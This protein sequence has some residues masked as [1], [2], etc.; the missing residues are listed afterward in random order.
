M[1][2]LV[3]ATL[4]DGTGAAPLED[5]EVEIRDG[6]IAYA[7]PRRSGTGPE[8]RTVDVSGA[9][10]LPGFVDV[11]VH[12]AMVPVAPEAARERF[13]EEDVLEIAGL[14][15]RTLDA[16]V[17]TARDLDGLSRA[18]ARPSHAA[19][20]R[21]RACTSRSP[22]SRRPAATPIRTTATAACRPGPCARACPHPDWWTRTRTSSAWSAR[23][24][25]RVPT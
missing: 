14:L 1:L 4:V 6:V 3:G 24:C 2:R 17:T 11:H 19:R 8:G 22:C 20:W 25:A 10:L 18:T 13:P 21:A 23:S 12:L 5:S 15:R 16:G 7:G 9:F